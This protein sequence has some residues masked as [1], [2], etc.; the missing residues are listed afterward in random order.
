[1][2]T[3][4]RYGLNGST[5]YVIIALVLIIGAPYKLKNPDISGIGEHQN[6]TCMKLA[7]YSCKHCTQIWKLQVKVH[8]M[9]LRS[10]LKNLM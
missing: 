6:S 9:V 1:M 7:C 2:K 4:R 8:E 10:V 5:P 3:T